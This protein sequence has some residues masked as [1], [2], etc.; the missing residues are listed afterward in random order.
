MKFNKNHYGSHHFMSKM[1]G[2]SPM[3]CPSLTISLHSVNPEKW[4]TVQPGDHFIA[5][6]IFLFNLE[7]TRR[8]RRSTAEDPQRDCA[9]PPRADMCRTPARLGG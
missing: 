1:P 2:M 7:L 9:S 5:T 4:R 3:V 6:T 8:D